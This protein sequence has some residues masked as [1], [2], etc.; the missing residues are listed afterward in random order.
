MSERHGRNTYRGRR[1]ARPRASRGSLQRLHVDDLL[2]K[3]QPRRSA[4]VE[5]PRALEPDRTATDPSSSRCVRSSAA[6]A[7]TRSRWPIV[8]CGADVDRGG[9]RQFRRTTPGLRVVARPRRCGLG[10]H[11]RG[12]DTSDVRGRIVNCRLTR[13]ARR[14]AEQSMGQRVTGC[15]RRRRDAAAHI[16]VSA[17]HPV[18]TMAQYFR[19]RRRSG[20]CAGDRGGVS[21]L[22]GH[23]M[24]PLF[25]EF[26]PVGP[27]Q[28]GKSS[29][30]AER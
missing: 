4:H 25:G 1:E 12:V 22:T 10:V 18:C 11:G 2:R 24:L 27:R 9:V 3:W 8:S 19:R 30:L 20:Y 26:L 5:F 28:V 6:T 15:G 14:H 21:N 23:F 17:P 13:R 7:A 29:V 16:H